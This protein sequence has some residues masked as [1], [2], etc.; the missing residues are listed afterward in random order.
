MYSSILL[1]FV[2]KNRKV[3][4]KNKE[5]Q[6]AVLPTFVAAKANIIHFACCSTYTLDYSI[7]HIYAYLY[8]LSWQRVFRPYMKIICVVQ[9]IQYVC[10]HNFPY[11]KYITNNIGSYLIT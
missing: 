9:G 7:I 4:E 2:P 3:Y 8:V 6:I 11:L 5:Y 10:Y 1:L